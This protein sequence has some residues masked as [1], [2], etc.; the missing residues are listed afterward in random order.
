MKLN[1]F[2]LSVI[3]L[4]FTSCYDVQK[5]EKPDHFLDE[6]EMT[7]VLV[8][9][10]IISAAKGIDKRKLEELNILPKEYVFQKHQIDSVIL[11][12]NNIY[13]SYHLEKYN[14]IY[15]RVN[16][17]L[18]TLKK[19]AQDKTLIKLEKSSVLKQKNL[20]SLKDSIP[21]KP[22]AFGTN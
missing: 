12:Q 8:D 18:N 5:P 6:N 2:L 14:S 16:D 7:H 17:S 10:A 21:K 20:K 13:Y 4:F 22:K 9:L 1:C 11:A 19:I 15:K 3:F